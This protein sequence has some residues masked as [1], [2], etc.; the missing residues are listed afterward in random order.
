MFSHLR[1]SRQ[2][3]LEL[4][5]SP[6]QSS[7]NDDIRLL[8]FVLEIY[9]YFVL[10]NN[11]TPFGA[12]TSRTLP[13]DTFLNDVLGTTMQCD[14]DEAIFGGSYG[15]FEFLPS[16]AAL[17][18][19]RLTE[20]QPSQESLEMYQALHARI[21]EWES[22]EPLIFDQKWQT[23]RQSALE[24]CRE[25]VLLSTETAMFPHAQWDSLIRG[26][27]LGHVDTIMLYAE[28]VSGSPYETILLCPLII[29]GSCMVRSDHRQ[30]LQSRLRTTRFHM[31]NCV[32]AAKLLELVWNDPNERIYGPYGLS[33]VMQRH[34]INLGI[35]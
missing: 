22:P 2:L 11:V 19:R 25:A 16:I 14:M 10:T 12:I 9:H 32:Q 8:S 35:S 24:L 21:A 4:A 27:V 5:N 29:A 18:S 7:T 13:H 31:N 33:V 30:C 1:A 26:R 15:L 3:I 6:L 20:K 17:A 28:H 34:S 23:Q